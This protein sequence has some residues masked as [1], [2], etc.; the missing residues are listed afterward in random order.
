VVFQV[1]T[2][3]LNNSEWAPSFALQSVN[4]LLRIVNS[5]LHM[6]NRDM[7]EMFLNFGLD[8]KV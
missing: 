1:G 8:W 5:N 3:K 7:G 2:N 6:S 4:S